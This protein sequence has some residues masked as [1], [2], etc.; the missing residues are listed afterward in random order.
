MWSWWGRAGGGYYSLYEDAP[1]VGGMDN[2]MAFGL[3]GGS[4]GK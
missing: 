1:V 3:L 2:C 4:W